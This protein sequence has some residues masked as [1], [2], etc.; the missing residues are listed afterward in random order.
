MVW[1]LMVQLVRVDRR[2][3]LPFNVENTIPSLCMLEVVRVLVITAPPF[4]V[5]ARIG[6]VERVEAVRVERVMVVLP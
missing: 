1:A 4:K 2:K 5:D 3:V 6:V